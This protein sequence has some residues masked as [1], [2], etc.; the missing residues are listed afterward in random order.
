MASCV[1]RVKLSVSCRS[2]LDR[3]LG[4]RSDPLCVLLQ[5]RAVAGGLSFAPVFVQLDCTKKIKNCQ[6]PEFCKKL[7]VDYYFEK[8]QKLK[9]SVYDTD[10]KSFDLNNDDYLGGIECTVGQGCLR[11]S[12]HPAAGI[13][14][15]KASR[16]GRYYSRKGFCLKKPSQYVVWDKVAFLVSC[17]SVFKSCMYTGERY[18]NE[19]T[20]YFMDKI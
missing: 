10:N 15:G 12:V 19:T 5:A 11:L 14:A 4:S 2:L 17:Q 6:D 9:F 1:S 7:V 20:V 8:V 13:E 16:R 18:L 3:D